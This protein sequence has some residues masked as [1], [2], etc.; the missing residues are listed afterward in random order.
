MQNEANR[1]RSNVGLLLNKY[2][3]CT[4]SS[5]GTPYIYILIIINFHVKLFSTC[6]VAAV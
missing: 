4:S 6:K 2:Y 1:K 3:I 5:V